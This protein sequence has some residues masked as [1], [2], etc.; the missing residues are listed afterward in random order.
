MKVYATF[1]QEVYVEPT[2]VI[3][4]LIKKEI[5]DT[6][7]NWIIEKDGR[8]FHVHEESAGCHSVELEDEIS[9]D[10]YEYIKA[11]QLVLER[12]S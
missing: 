12:L 3:K 7:Y 8:Y 2:Q 6:N 1:S 10:K 9:K 4:N 11:L 5:G